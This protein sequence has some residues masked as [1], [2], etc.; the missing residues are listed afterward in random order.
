MLD[1]YLAIYFSLLNFGNNGILPNYLLG[2][3]AYD[4]FKILTTEKLNKTINALENPETQYKNE[5]IDNYIC[6]LTYSSSKILAFSHA[7]KKINHEPF[8]LR[9]DF[10]SNDL[11]KIFVRLDTLFTSFNS[12]SPDNFLQEMTFIM[13]DLFLLFEVRSN[14]TGKN[15]RS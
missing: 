5:L 7:Y 11:A 13:G 8:S 1:E 12:I 9:I 3:D 14:T 15:D 2:S 4:L 10:L 6:E